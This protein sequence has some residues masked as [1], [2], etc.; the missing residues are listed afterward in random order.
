MLLNPVK[1]EHL[2]HPQATPQILHFA[3][4]DPVPTSRIIQ[5]SR[6]TSLM[7]QPFKIAM[8]DRNSK[9]QTPCMKLQQLWRGKLNTRAKGQNFFHSTIVPALPYGL[10]TLPL[11][12][13]HFKTTDAWH[14]KFLRGVKALYYS[15]VSNRK[16]WI[17]AGR[18]KMPSQF[19]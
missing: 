16:A 17:F 3:K 15:R 18:P 9:A 7:G 11:E 4:G 5:I 8:E 10:E 2:P 13:R 14:H 19:C 1:T 6:H 12:L